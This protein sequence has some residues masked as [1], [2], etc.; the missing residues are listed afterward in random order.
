MPFDSHGNPLWEKFDYYVV[1]DEIW[2]EAG[3]NG[4]DSGHLCTSCLE[5]RLGRKTN[6]RRLSRSPNQ[7]DQERYRN[8]LP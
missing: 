7:R 4:W 2:S 8:V 1:R 5:R 6:E 3:L